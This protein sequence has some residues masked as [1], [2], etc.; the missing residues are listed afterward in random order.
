MPLAAVIFDMDGLLI[1]SERQANAAWAE[2][3]RELGRELPEEALYRCVGVDEPG[4]RAIVL[5]ALGGDVDIAALAA[6]R[7]AIG[8][9]W[10]EAR[11]MPLRPW[12][13]EM[14][15]WVTARGLPIAVATSSARERTDWK[16]ERAGLT[17]R[18]P[19]VCTRDDVTNPKPAP[20][21]YL[22]AARG[23]GIDPAAC[24]VF[25]DSTP[26]AR[27]ALAAGMRVIVVPDMHTPPADVAAAALA[28]LDTLADAPAVL[29]PLLP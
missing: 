3:A 2:A 10:T 14:V 25:E 5:A 8:D 26:G 21:V 13:R 9:A 24:L 18:F 7:E 22:L 6:R 23:L 29:A 28:V 16:L 11:G 12:A 17:G 20:D 19:V 15:E 4:T 27:A 1:D